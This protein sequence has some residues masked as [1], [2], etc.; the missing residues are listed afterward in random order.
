[1]PEVTGSCV[2]GAVRYASSAQP[3]TIV[4][5]HCRTCQ[6]SSGSGYSPNVAVPQDSVSVEGPLKSYRT[7][8]GSGKALT[9]SFCS[10]CGSQMTIEVESFSGVTLIQA[11][12]LDDASWVEPDVH[13]WCSSAQ[14]WDHLPEGANCLPGSPPASA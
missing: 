3:L 13:I 1:M 4:F 9:R 6:K 5:C 12:S 7:L 2:C 14:P 11:G 10:E 8:G